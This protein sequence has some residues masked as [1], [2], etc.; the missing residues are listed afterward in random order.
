MT[1]GSKAAATRVAPVTCLGCGCACDDLTVQVE[2][3]QI[4]DISPPCPLGR[5]WFGDGRVPSRV[6]LDGRDSSLESA[7]DEAAGLLAGARERLVVV[8][9]PDAS[10]QTQRTT[11]ALADL[12]RASVDTATSEPAAAGLLTAQRRGRA[13]ATLGEIRNRADVVMFWGVDPALHYPRYLSRY[14]VDP[15]GTHVSAGRAGRTLISVSIG[16]DRGPAGAEIALTLAPDA[17]VTALSI[18]RAVALGNPLGELPAA[19]QSVADAA[20]RLVKARYAAVVHD[21]EPGEEPSRDAYRTEG[22]IALTQALN[23]PT[24]AAL[25]SLRA[26]GNRSGAEAALTWQTGYPMAVSFRPGYPRY[27]PTRRGLAELSAGE[28][29][30]LLVVGSTA[31]LGGGLAEVAV[32]TDVVVIGPR[33]SETAFPTRVAID[34]GMP[35]IHEG[36]TGYR[37]DEVPLPLRPPLG[38]LRTGTETMAALLAAVQ[39]RVAGTG[40]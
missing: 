2:G 27:T 22:L 5:A 31:E 14:A 4:V 36:G 32:K 18:M 6:L 23:G 11:L 38:G 28:A 34:T 25:S 3:G 33:A 8:L 20:A 16:A 1:P 12:L 26:G 37:M 35:G 17:E 39:A 13:A 19:L 10:S 21:A 40:A 24:R 29:S 9:A 30:A 15:I 7:L